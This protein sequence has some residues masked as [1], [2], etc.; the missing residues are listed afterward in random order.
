ML[1]GEEA[2]VEAGADKHAAVGKDGH[3]VIGRLPEFVEEVG[4][5]PVEVGESLAAGR[6][7]VHVV[8]VPLLCV[9]ALQVVVAL[10]LPLA[11][12]HLLQPVVEPGAGV[13]AVGGQTGGTGQR[14][15]VYLVEGFV[16][17]EVLSGGGGLLFEGLCYGHV[18]LPVAGAPGHVDA[19]M[20]DQ[21]YFH[22]NVNIGCWAQTT[23]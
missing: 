20:S 16:G 2:G 11:H 17:R 7:Q 23:R 3:A 8:V 21:Y 15:G 6:R 13:A 18:A 4:H 14:R 12:V 19:G 22:G 1:G 5:A 10:H 9:W